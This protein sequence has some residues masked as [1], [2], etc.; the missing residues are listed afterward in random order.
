M[1]QQVT[2]RPF[3]VQ[4][5]APKRVRSAGARRK[6]SRRAGKEVYAGSVMAK[7]GLCAAAGL[8]VLAL[9]VF[10]LAPGLLDDNA[11]AVM[12]AE[13]QADET[14]G[15]LQFVELPGAISVFAPASEPFSLPVSCDVLHVEQGDTLTVINCTPAA[16]VVAAADG[17]VRGVGTD[18]AF[19]DYVRLA[20]A[21]GLETL[22]YGLSQIAVEEGQP[23]RA[24]DTLG[25][26]SKSGV[27]GMQVLREGRPVSAA[28]YFDIG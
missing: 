28:A 17:E 24:K 1:R 5:S 11:R 15:K 20:H 10:E 8:L 6:K 7:L 22:Y 25:T 19:G 13:M 9:N 26:L 12:E 3:T 16:T 27:L 21:D 18:G 2:M 4:P 23:V 14:L